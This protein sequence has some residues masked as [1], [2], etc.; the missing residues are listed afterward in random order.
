MG[1][2]VAAI[3]PGVRALASH[4]WYGFPGIPV[5]RP[6]LYT[7]LTPG[8]DSLNLLKAQGERIPRLGKAGWPRPLIKILPKASLSR[9]RAGRLVHHR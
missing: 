8:G 6:G 1:A 7:H 2:G 9:E 5:P 3:E 4:P